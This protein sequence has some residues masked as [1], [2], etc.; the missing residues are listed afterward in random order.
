MDGDLYLI[1][2]GSIP[3]R[4]FKSIYWGGPG[5]INNVMNRAIKRFGGPPLIYRG[6]TP[7]PVVISLGY[8][9]HTPRGGLKA[10]F[11]PG[12]FLTSPE[13]RNR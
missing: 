9:E 13:A 1:L 7:L 6:P 10:Q 12:V 3:Q 5:D 8:I 11:L 4:F 2:V